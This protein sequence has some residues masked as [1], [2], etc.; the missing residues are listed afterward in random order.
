MVSDWGG[1]FEEEEDEENEVEVKDK[2]EERETEVVMAEEEVVTEVKWVTV[3]EVEV[4]GGS[5]LSRWRWRIC[6][7]SRWGDMQEF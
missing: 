5:L 2:E 3:A 7:G 6:K 1:L 4:G